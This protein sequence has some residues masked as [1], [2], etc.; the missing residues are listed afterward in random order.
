MITPNKMESYNQS[1]IVSM[2]EELNKKL[3]KE[4]IQKIKEVDYVSGF[5]KSQIRAIIK[6]GGKEIFKKALKETNKLTAKRKKEVQNVYDEIIEEQLKGY[7]NQFERVGK[8]YGVSRDMLKLLDYMIKSTN[9]TLQNMTKSV[10]FATKKEFTDAMGELYKQVVSG[11]KDY[12]SAMKDVVRKLADKGITLKS[13][14]KN[15]TLE[16]M[17]RLNLMTGLTQ[18][19]N[20]IAKSI[21]EAIDY[22]CVEIGHSYKCRP[23]H[24]VIDDVVM[25]KEEFKK[26]EH[27]T[28]EYN[29][30]HIVNYDWREEFEDKNHKVEYGQE[31]QTLE[32]TI[33]NYKIQ[34]KARYY[35]R[36]IRNRK[37]A[38]A[39]GDTSFEA[40]INLR[41]AQIKYKTFCNAN[42]IKM[43]GLRTWQANYNG[44]NSV[45]KHIK[46][47]KKI[48][49]TESEK[50]AI[51]KY[52]GFNSYVYNEKLRQEMD[53][54]NEE[55][56]ILTD[57]DKALEKM[58]IYKGTVTRSISIMSDDLDM[59]LKKYSVGS[60]ITEKAYTSTTK[61]EIYNPEAR[62]QMTI[63]SK[64]GKDISK[65][66]EQEQ[67][68]LF[69]RGT[70]FKILKVDTS[71]DFYVK[72][73]LE[74]VI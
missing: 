64:S 23:T 68:I 35:E 26:Y 5:T 67:E 30:Y 63:K 53:L 38:I 60:I 2:Y 24:N 33:E 51:N 11:Q 50:Y 44:K 49:L 48:G 9:N 12:V 29:C 6:T 74:E 73:E 55:A 18:T 28:E 37:K 57:L 27:L 43:N 8:T 61:G 40:K 4:I 42:G 1:Q 59:F 69:S 72:I 22:N 71:E 54:T 20:A 47:S 65:Y 31:H 39:R 32:K 17:A 62:V 58:P 36:Q 10:A 3:T 46:T 34:Q 14:G 13:K 41:N 45:K 15:Y 16:S 70:K 52:I 56:K 66:N 25:S 21:G 7:E 19:T